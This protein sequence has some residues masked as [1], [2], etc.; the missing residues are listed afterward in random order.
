M[1]NAI[2]I[3]TFLILAFF[4]NVIFF[5][6]SSDYRNFLQDFKRD[7]IATTSEVKDLETEIADNISIE[8]ENLTTIAPNSKNE[9][10]FIQ[11][12][13]EII[14]VKEEVVL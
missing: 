14:E 5:Y 9:E 8:D 7:K 4:V 10:I 1:R 6:A 3:I 13:N 12:E 2:L 11:N